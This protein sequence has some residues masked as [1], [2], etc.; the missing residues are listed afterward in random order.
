V[1][2]FSLPGV[3]RPLAT[4]GTAAAATAFVIGFSLLARDQPLIAVAIPFVLLFAVGCIRWPAA[5]VT[6]LIA[7]SGT[8]G[9]LT[10]FGILPAGPMVDLILSALLAGTI[11]SQLLGV[12]DRPW[13]IWP[14]VAILVLYVAITFLEIAT[15]ANLGLGI[16]SFSYQAWYML[17]VPLLALAGWSLP[18]YMRIYRSLLAVAVFVAGYA[19]FRKLAGPAASEQALGLR[20]AGVFNTV[21]GD[22]KLLGSFPNRHELAFWVTTAAPFAFAVMLIDPRKSWKMPAAFTMAGCVAA[23]YAT[24][25]RAALPALIAGGGAVIVLNQIAG[26]GKVLA[27]T[28]ASL[29]IAATVGAVLFTVIVG[30]DSSRYGAILN[31]SGD[32]SYQS[33]LTKWTAAIQDLHGH[34]FGLGLGTAGRLAEQGAGPFITEGTYAIDSSYLKIAYEQGFPVLVLFAI[35]IIALLVELMRRSVRARSPGVRALAIGASGALMAAIPMWVTGQY[36]E[37]LDTL[38]LWISIGAAIG[39]IS[40]ERAQA[41]R[42]GPAQQPSAPPVPEPLPADQRA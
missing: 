30:P 16:K 1:R 3:R 31:P 37:S 26:R 33:H 6:G 40:A 39:A 22:L 23:A 5:A 14:G 24:D 8:Y 27:Q 34:P 11:L 12:R 2:G 20:S 7:I 25:V 18:T 10:A 17:L 38:F 9:S 42:E 15:A 13:W 35:A 32:V 41:M 4:A 21:G 28:V 36:M 19:V 29:A